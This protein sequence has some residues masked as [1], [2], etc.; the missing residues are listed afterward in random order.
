M[1]PQPKDP[2]AVSLGRKGGLAGRGASKARDP[3]KMRRAV[4][5]REAKRRQRKE[6]K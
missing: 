2:A 1:T 4:Q 6:G 5:A 3:E